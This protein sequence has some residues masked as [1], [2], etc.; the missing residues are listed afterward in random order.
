[1][2]K[3]KCGGISICP[4]NQEPLWNIV[5]EGAQGTETRHLAMT[6]QEKAA[7]AALFE[8]SMRR[9]LLRVAFD[10]WCY[11]RGWSWIRPQHLV[12]QSLAMLVV[13]RCAT[14]TVKFITRKL[15]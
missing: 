10:V 6:T 12:P 2:D 9:H 15:Q 1:M 11:K 14:A 4:I 13:S 7:V 8:E 5:R 3:F